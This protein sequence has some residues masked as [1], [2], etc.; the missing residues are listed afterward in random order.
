MAAS[1]QEAENKVA[2]LKEQWVPRVREIVSE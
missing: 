2:S 1:L